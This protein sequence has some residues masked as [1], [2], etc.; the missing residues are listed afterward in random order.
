MNEIKELVIKTI[1]ISLNTKKTL[2]IGERKINDELSCQN[3]DF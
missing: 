3:F 1:N 2:K